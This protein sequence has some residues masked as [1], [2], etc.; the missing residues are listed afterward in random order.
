MKGKSASPRASDGAIHPS[1][2]CRVD[3]FGGD[4][5][6]VHD[7]MSEPDGDLSWLRDYSDADLNSESTSSFT[8][9]SI[10]G[11]I[12]ASDDDIRHGAPLQ[13]TSLFTIPATKLRHFYI[14]SR[15]AH[16]NGHVSFQETD[17]DKIVVAMDYYYWL[18]AMRESINLCHLVTNGTSQG[19]GIFVSTVFP[20]DTLT[21]F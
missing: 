11:A 19:F 2:S 14:V 12:L 5:Q 8:T 9:N 17:T 7:V 4:V 6:T 18:P 20:F 16:A 3:A 1:R 10:F 21:P 13:S 15:G